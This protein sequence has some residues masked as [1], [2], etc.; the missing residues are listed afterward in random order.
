[1][2]V[3]GALEVLRVERYVRKD[4]REGWVIVGVAPGS[5]YPEPVALSVAE[6]NGV[7]VGDV[8]ELEARV[9]RVRRADGWGWEVGGWRVV[10]EG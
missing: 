6:L 10:Q 7:R 1:V 3:R 9:R 8:V 2:R 5:E 4:G